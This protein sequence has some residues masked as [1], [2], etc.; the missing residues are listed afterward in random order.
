MDGVLISSGEHEV[1]KLTAVLYSPSP[2]YSLLFP[3]PPPPPALKNLSFSR[4]GGGGGVGREFENRLKYWV[5]HV[6]GNRWAMF[7]SSSEN[8]SGSYVLLFLWSLWN[9]LDTRLLKG[10]LLFWLDLSI[11]QFIKVNAW[12]EVTHHI[13]VKHKTINKNKNNVKEKIMPLFIYFDS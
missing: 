3:P 11:N 13:W 2:W 6:P 5:N 9:F 1:D 8:S 7:G 12:D 4:G 10:T